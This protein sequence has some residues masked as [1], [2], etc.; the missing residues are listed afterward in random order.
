MYRN[1]GKK[2]KGLAVFIF[3]LGLVSAA[4]AGVGIVFF[5]TDKYVLISNSLGMRIL[6]GVVTF[7]LGSLGAWISTWC[8]YGFGELI[9]STSQKKQC[10]HGRG[11]AAEE[12]KYKCPN[13]GSTVSRGDSKCDSCG[14]GFYWY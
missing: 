3:V 5:Q 10:A 9:D 4:G 13:C 1:I 12:K 7:L 11:R 6:A 14:Q 8:L 2:I